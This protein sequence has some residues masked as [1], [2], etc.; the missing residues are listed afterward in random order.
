[1]IVNSWIL[2]WSRFCA[3]KIATSAVARSATTSLGVIRRPRPTEAPPDVVAT[4]RPS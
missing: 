4:V 3:T 2:T 1:V